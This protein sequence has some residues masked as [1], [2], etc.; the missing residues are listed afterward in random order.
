MP[1]FA[2]RNW[3]TPRRASTNRILTAIFRLIS[4]EHIFSKLLKRTDL[5]NN[6]KNSYLAWKK[7]A[8][9]NAPPF[10]CLRVKKTKGFWA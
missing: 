10:R 5:K 3:Q 4:Q 9:Q 1:I 6:L 8:G 2:N 7:I